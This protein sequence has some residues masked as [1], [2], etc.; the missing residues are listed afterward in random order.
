MPV[1][2]VREA[3]IHRVRGSGHPLLLFAPGGLR[4]HLEFW[5]HGPSNP[6]AP[7]TDV[8]ARH[9]P[10]RSRSAQLFAPAWPTE[11]RDLRLRW[12]PR[13]HRADR[14][15]RG[16]DRPGAHRVA[17]DGGGDRR[18]VRRTH[19]RLHARRDPEAS[20]PCARP[21]L[22]R[23][24]PPPLPGGVRCRASTG[25]RDRRGAR[26]H[27]HADLRRVEREPREDALHARQDG[28]L[29]ALRRPHLQRG[30]GPTT[31]SLRPTSS[32]TRRRGWASRPP[33]AR[34]SRTARSGS[35]PR[36]PPA[37][38]YS[39]T[40]AASRRPLVWR[41]RARSSFA[42]CA[43]CRD[44]SA[45]H[46][47]GHPTTSSPHDAGH[48]PWACPSTVAVVG[49]AHG[50]AS[51]AGVGGDSGAGCPCVSPTRTSVRCVSSTVVST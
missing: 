41:A 8:L 50:R 5:R 23:G 14:G 48:A 18:A 19:G 32:C 44:C 26:P 17:A 24:V 11:A 10:R 35:R 22:G 21:R 39:A 40:R 51:G 46:R 47:S 38:R 29:R 37:C 13:G 6:S 30:R 20:R 7:V 34:S 36:A 27:P 2:N 31:A 1:F 4:S 3:E 12:S 28:S 9:T 15:P 25:G 49:A 45:A 42:T 33:T 16:R 43:S